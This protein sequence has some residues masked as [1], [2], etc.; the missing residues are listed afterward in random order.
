MTALH[1][2]PSPSKV[3]SWL[4]WN[5]DAPALLSESGH[6]LRPAGPTLHVRYRT[7]GAE[8]EFW[9]VS[10]EEARKV[11][12]PGQVYDFSIGRAFGDVIKA[13]KSGRMVK[14][15]QRQETVKQREAQ[16][17]R[18]GRRWLA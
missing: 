11:M 14:L 8:F 4:E 5:P 13:H 12:Q 10:E 2:D 7:T 18:S 15:G 17:K 1:L 6:T 16:E 3:F 9:P